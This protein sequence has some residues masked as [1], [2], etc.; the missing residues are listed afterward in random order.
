MASWKGV[1]PAPGPDSTPYVADGADLTEVAP[2]PLEAETKRLKNLSLPIGKLVD[3]LG[4]ISKRIAEETQ[5][6]QALRERLIDCEGAKARALA[7][8]GEREQGY[9][10]YAI[11]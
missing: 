7:L 4:A 1:T 9:M 8:A 10:Y 6:L 3:K 11:L 2:A 5:K